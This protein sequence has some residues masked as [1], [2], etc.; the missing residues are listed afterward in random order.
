MLFIYINHR[1]QYPISVFCFS[2]L[3][4]SD[5]GWILFKKN[6]EIELLWVIIWRLLYWAM[7][8]RG[9]ILESWGL[10]HHPLYTLSN[11]FLIYSIHHSS[12]ASLLFVILKQANSWVSTRILTNAMSKR[13]SSSLTSPQFYKCCKSFHLFGVMMKCSGRGEN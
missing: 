11:F 12:L 1:C 5:G 2:P 10:L 4:K 13:Y 6:M 8:K 3:S 9:V 7:A